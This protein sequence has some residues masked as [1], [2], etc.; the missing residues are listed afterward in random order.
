MLRFEEECDQMVEECCIALYCIVLKGWSLLPNALRPFQI[1]C[2]PP[3][4]GIRTWICRLNFPWR[5]IFSGLRFCNE[6]DISELQ[7]PPGG[8]VLR[9]FMSWKNPSTS[10]GFEPANLGSWGEH[11]TTRQPRPRKRV[12]L[13]RSRSEF[14]GRL[15]TSQSLM[16]TKYRL[17]RHSGSLGN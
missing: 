16:S 9:I 3:N 15:N 12:L 10:P 8:R 11:V 2:A 13:E 1:Y 17:S 4:L 14:W 6:P 7:V 5:P